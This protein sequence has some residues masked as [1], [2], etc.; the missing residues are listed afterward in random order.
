MAQYLIRKG[1]LV[2]EVSKFDDSD[3]PLDVYTIS[4]RGCNCPARSRNCKHY[5]MK[6][7]WETNGSLLGEVYDDSIKVIGYIFS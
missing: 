1:K 2:H 3:T 7:A 4:S 5:R 6:K